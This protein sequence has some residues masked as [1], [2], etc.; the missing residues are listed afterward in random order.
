MNNAQP[1]TVDTAGLGKHIGRTMHL[2]ASG[3][4]EKR[5]K[6]KIMFYGQSIIDE[7]NPW[8]KFLVQHL[9]AQYP[10]TDIEPVYH[11]AVGGFSTQIMHSLAPMDAKCEYPD[12]VIVLITGS[13]YDYETMV[14]AFRENTTAEVMILTNH[15]TRGYKNNTTTWED[16]MANEHLPNIARLYGAELCPLRKA[17]RAHLLDNDLDETVY[18]G[19]DGGHL[20]AEGQRLMLSIVKQFFV[21]DEEAVAAA[22]KILDNEWRDVREDDW[23]DGTLTLPFRGNRVI[24]ATEDNKYQPVVE[25]RINGKKPSEWPELYVHPRIGHGWMAPGF[26]RRI[27]IKAPHKPQR[28]TIDFTRWELVE[29]EGEDKQKFAFAYTVTGELNGFMGASSEGFYYQ[30]GKWSWQNKC[31]GGDFDSDILRIKGEDFY[32]GMKKAF[33]GAKAVF[34]IKVNGADLFDIFNPLVASGLPIG[35]YVLTLSALNKGFIP[36]INRVRICN[37]E[38]K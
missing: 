19:E 6:L 37:P 30:G 13:H 10:F 2:L 9:N 5:A 17:W 20:N 8:P 29:N 22:G 7:N 12:L 15:I 4:P 35:D 26:L 3:T 38:K 27:E 18:L 1:P 11:L 32:F 33:V 28:W 16:T 36:K 14:K 34:E 24:V 31:E 23:K 21:R 25:V